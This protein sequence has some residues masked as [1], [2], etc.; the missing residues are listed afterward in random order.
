M[1]RSTFSIFCFIECY[2]L[3][4]KFITVF[5]VTTSV[6]IQILILFRV[7]QQPDAGDLESGVESGKRILQFSV[8][9]DTGLCDAS[10]CTQLN[11]LPHM[12]VDMYS[13]ISMCPEYGQKV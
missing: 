5:A 10:S 12:I 9:R 2:K 6:T 7:H 11:N 8:R 13:K 1:E 4:I 3:I